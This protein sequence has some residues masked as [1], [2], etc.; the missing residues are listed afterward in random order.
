MG[1]KHA[2]AL[3]ACNQI[4]QK[5]KN[6]MGEKGGK[7]GEK[8]SHPSGAEKW[9]PENE[10]WRGKQTKENPGTGFLRNRTVAGWWDLSLGGHANQHQWGEKEIWNSGGPVGET[11]LAD[12]FKEAE[13]PK[14]TQREK[15][16]RI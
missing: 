9:A 4:F 13:N 11:T 15:Q 1:G 6:E 8:L 10:P 14:R 5:E 16:N 12:G 2:T 3:A 7:K